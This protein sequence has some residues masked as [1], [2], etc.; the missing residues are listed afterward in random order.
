M[1]R[2]RR[3]SKSRP[4]ELNH[5]QYFDLWLDEYRGKWRKNSP[6]ESP[7]DR[8]VAWFANRDELLANHNAG[9]RP[10]GWWDYEAPEPRPLIGQREFPGKVLCWC[11]ELH[12]GFVC[13]YEGDKDYLRRLGLLEPWEEADLEARK[14]IVGKE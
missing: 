4:T 13:E 11:G 7:F 10:A 2:K 3:T 6:F 14:W 1:P 12:D 9:D 8:R 5:L